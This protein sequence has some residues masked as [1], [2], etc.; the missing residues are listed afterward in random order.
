MRHFTGGHSRD[1]P[2]LASAARAQQT[3]VEI[4]LNRQGR[5]I[6][7]EP[8]SGL[9]LIA[10]DSDLHRP[11]PRLLAKLMKDQLSR[12]GGLCF[13]VSD[14]AALVV[15]AGV[16]YSLIVGIENSLADAL[17]RGGGTHPAPSG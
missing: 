16:E 4:R 12:V 3:S 7:S 13:G 17:A 9:K 1:A 10:L 11:D 5:E 8:S 6:C 14:D 15:S 2:P